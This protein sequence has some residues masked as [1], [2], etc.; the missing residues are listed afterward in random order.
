MVAKKSRLSI[1]D[2]ELPTFSSAPKH[3]H[4]VTTQCKTPKQTRSKEVGLKGETVYSTPEPS[5]SRPLCHFCI[6][7]CTKFR[8]LTFTFLVVLFI[9]FITVGL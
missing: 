1:Y 5:K 4:D 8:I 7:S 9:F 3:Y 2:P 6:L